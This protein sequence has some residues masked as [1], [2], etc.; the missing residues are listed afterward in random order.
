MKR[1]VY[2]AP[3]FSATTLHCLRALIALPDATIG[4]VSQDPPERLPEAERAAIAGHYKVADS[5]D[6]DQLVAAG[7]AFQRQWGG[8]DCLLG[9]LEQMQIPLAIAR[10]RLGV[11]G[12]G[13]AVARNFREK[14][15]MKQVLREAGLPVAR[16]A[17]LTG[18]DDAYRFVAEVGYPIVVKPPAGLG[19]KATMRVGD[20][21]EL[22]AALEAMVV[23]PNNPVQAEE[24]IRGEEHTFETMSVKGQPVWS[25]STVYLNG[26]LEVLENPWMQYCVLL[27]REQ[28]APHAEAVRGKNAAALSALG[29][30]TGLSHMEWFRRAD[31]S[32]V[33]SEVA[34]R[35]PGVNIMMMMGHAHG[36]D[37]WQK[38]A[39]LMVHERVSMPAR[40]AACGCAFFRGQ[41]RG[42]VV[43]EVNGLAE[44]QEKVGAL[45]IDRKLPRVG[46]ARGPG[47]EGEGWAIVRA[48][49][50]RAVLDALRVLVT[51]VRVH[52]G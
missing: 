49:D 31:G 11:P 14:N 27:P 16:Q 33:I 42:Q 2:V 5:L 36:V 10:D 51:T 47:Y 24:F 9:F 8:V 46:Q 28:L 26:P 29:M 37:M 20:D 3:Y 39:E 30:G 19:S 41:G 15:R 13:Q 32:P 22:L 4:V 48:P 25:S 43:T 35:P 6:P 52:L 34:A 17:L 12:M 40:Q 1:V 23:S 50:T 45:V 44:A 21:E 7:R 38:W 18:S